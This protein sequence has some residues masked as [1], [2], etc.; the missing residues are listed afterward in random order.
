MCKLV[1]NYFK[2][3]DVT[4][5]SKILIILFY[6]ASYLVLFLLLFVEP[7]VSTDVVILRSFMFLFIFSC[8]FCFKFWHGIQNFIPNMWQ[9]VFANIFIQGS[10]VNSYIYSFFYNS[11]HIM[12][13]PAY[14]WKVVHCCYVASSVLVLKYW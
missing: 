13:L 6:F 4:Y 2:G 14:D 8:L 1:G 12:L 10:V 9:V 7:H 3:T 11:N 5:L